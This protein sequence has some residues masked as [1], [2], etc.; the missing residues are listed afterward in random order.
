MC[1]YAKQKTREKRA[2]FKLCP[3]SIPLLPSPRSPLSPLAAVREYSS[4]SAFFWRVLGALP[5]FSWSQKQNRQGNEYYREFS[6]E[7]S[8]L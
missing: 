5:V 3:P 4:T 1:S 8:L 7:N 2:A 6:E